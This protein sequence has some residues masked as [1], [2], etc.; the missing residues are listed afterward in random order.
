MNRFLLGIAI[1]ASHL[2]ATFPLSAMES[3]LARP[4]GT[5]PS[6]PHDTRLIFWS[7]V[8][9][10]LLF[11]KNNPIEITCRS[12]LRSVSLRWTVARNMFKAPFLEGTADAL[13]DNRYLIR[14]PANALKPGFYDLRVFL[15]PGNGETVPGVC[16]FGYQADD[17]PITTSRP[18]DFR[19]FWDK[20][21]LELKDVLYFVV[22]SLLFL[23]ITK[24]VVA[25]K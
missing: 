9:D 20:G 1:F 23:M 6:P 22:I 5:Q 14:I 16:T 8:A 13:P 17:M 19:K 2:S 25:R 12:G 21:L 10:D 7:G 3:N 15:D 11:S 18:E 24:R 4:Y